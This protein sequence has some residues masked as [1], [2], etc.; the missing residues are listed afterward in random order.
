MSDAASGGDVATEQ[1]DIVSST[2]RLAEWTFSLQG[3]GADLKRLMTEVKD[4][5]RSQMAHWTDESPPPDPERD[6]KRF[7]ELDYV[8]SRAA[9]RA[10]VEIRSDHNTGSHGRN[11]GEKSWKDKVIIPLLVVA[12]SGG[13]ATYA[14]VA[15][16]ETKIEEKD[17]AT[18]Q[19]LDDFIRA[20]QQRHEETERRVSRLEGKVFP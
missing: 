8:A 14:K 10:T 9:R 6:R 15:S 16:L 18:Q 2:K 19:R 3:V 1:E 12:I 4:W 13:I 7:D 11:N 17:R 5:A 20:N